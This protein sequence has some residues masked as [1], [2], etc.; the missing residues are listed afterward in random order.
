MS[1]I[2][3]MFISQKGIEKNRVVEERG[4]ASDENR[5]MRI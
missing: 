5:G 1:K 4:V 2:E 3:Y